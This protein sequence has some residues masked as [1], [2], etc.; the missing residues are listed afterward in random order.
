LTAPKHVTAGRKVQ[1]Y[2][3]TVAKL[4][5]HWANISGNVTCQAVAR[6]DD[7]R[8]SKGPTQQLWSAVDKYIE[9]NMRAANNEAWADAVVEML[10][11]V[12]IEV[13]VH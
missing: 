10:I 2:S 12:T 5:Q 3:Y 13:Y 4:S 8:R 11:I 1:L 6:D 7:F 9:E